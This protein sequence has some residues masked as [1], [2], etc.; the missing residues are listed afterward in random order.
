MRKSPQTS[1]LQ[2]N[3]ARIIFYSCMAEPKTIMQISKNWGYQS[4]TYLYQKNTIEEMSRNNLIRLITKDGQ[5]SIESNYDVIFEKERLDTF[6]KKLNE[7][8][9]TETI[10]KEYDYDISEAQLEDKLFREFCIQKKENLQRKINGI[11]FDEKDR[12]LLVHLWENLV[13]RKVFLDLEILSKLVRRDELPRNP[14]SL[15]FDVTYNVFERIYSC[16]KQIEYP[17][18]FYSP[19]LYFRIEDVIFPLIETLSELNKHEM[20]TLTNCFRKAYNA[21]EKKSMTYEPPS[22]LRLYHMK[23]LVELLGITN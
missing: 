8:I 17:E 16:V 15:L 20:A 14:V 11:R 9:E 6:F 4:V 13:F 3:R 5:R 10:V 22:E 23:R 18:T 2:D 19:D 7:D 1:L 12:G 21:V